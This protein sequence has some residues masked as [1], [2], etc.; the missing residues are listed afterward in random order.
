[1]TRLT[2]IFGSAAMA[3]IFVNPANAQN[4][5]RDW[6][7]YRTP[8][9]A[10]WSSAKLSEICRNGNVASLFLVYDGKVVFTYG[11]YGRRFKIHSVRKSILS[12]LYGLAVHEG[13]IDP[14]RSLKEL[15]V[16]D[17]TPL[18]ESEKTA[19]IMD[20]LKSRSGVYLPAASES[21]N[22]RRERPERNSHPAGAYFYYN[23]WDFNVLGTIY[24]QETGEDLFE[25]FRRRISRQLGMEDF[26]PLD[27]CYDFEDTSA[28]PAYNFK[29]SARD[30]AR[31]GQLFLQDGRWGGRQIIPE[32]WVK[33]STASESRTNEDNIVT[34]DKVGYGYL[35]WTIENYKGFKIFY[36]AGTYGQRIVVVPALKIVL[37]TQ[38]NSYI[39]EGISD[40][41]FVIDD[42]LFKSRVSEARPNPSF[43]ALEAPA[44][45]RALKLTAEE[46][47]KYCRDYADG[48]TAFRIERDDR[49][50]VL[51]GFHFFYRFPLIPV[52]VNLLYA[53]DIDVYIFLQRDVRGF[54]IKAEIHKSPLVK[55]MLDAITGEGLEKALGKFPE[56]R[57]QIASRDEM[58]ALAGEL[59]K[60]GISPVEILKLNA[61]NYP[62]S[63]HVQQMLNDA[64]MKDGGLASSSKAFGEIVRTLRDEGQ[65]KTKAEWLFEIIDSQAHP[66]SLDENER[67]AVCGDYENRQIILE[68]QDLYSVVNGGQKTRLYKIAPNEFSLKGQ[69]FRRL[70]FE[71]DARGKAVKLI[72]NYYRDSSE[73][74]ARTGGMFMID[75]YLECRIKAAI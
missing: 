25:A 56:W 65:A 62:D 4:P 61:L 44:E 16:D 20:L 59:G 1:M 22:Q 13:K 12:A 38:A 29:M 17:K 33:A 66:R 21:A 9:D 7:C 72:M 32:A 74:S 67:A 19:R 10:G 71:T 53:D 58:V 55:T 6:R 73:E 70:K 14:N 68:G 34:G 40:V 27:G 43:V 5:S 11:D 3:F 2:R 8:E 28:H 47:Q 51:T 50:L 18:T 54:P 64:L 63:F 37:V 52:T 15:K 35:W 42:V 26:R 60:R 45:V 30:L 23:N 24:R 57:K 41:D 49:L 31:F 36:A 39:P 75:E 46:Q 48:D 69:F